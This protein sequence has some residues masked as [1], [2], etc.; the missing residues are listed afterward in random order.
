MLYPIIFLPFPVKSTEGTIPS[1][2]FLQGNNNKIIVTFHGQGTFCHDVAEFQM[3][4]LRRR[5]THNAKEN[6]KDKISNTSISQAIKVNLGTL[7]V[8]NRSYP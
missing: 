6:I 7:G 2:V 8:A 4:C 1:C 5:D 3:R